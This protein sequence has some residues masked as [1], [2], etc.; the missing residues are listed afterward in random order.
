[1]LVQGND[2]GDDTSFGRFLLY[3]EAIGTGSMVRLQGMMLMFLVLM[4]LQIVECRTCIL[5]LLVRRV[6]LQ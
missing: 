6:G 2:G 5:V 1:M 3:Q 4:T